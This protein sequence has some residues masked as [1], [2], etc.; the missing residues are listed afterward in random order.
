M[1]LAKNILFCALM[2]MSAPLTSC[3]ESLEERA[4]R[5]AREYTE[6]H[7]PTPP[8]NDVITD[9]IVFDRAG[10][11]SIDEIMKDDAGSLGGVKIK[12]DGVLMDMVVKG[13]FIAIGHNPNTDLFKGQVELKDN[14]Y[15]K[16]EA[17]S[18]V[19][20]SVEGVFAAGDVCDDKYRQAI[21]SAGAGCK[22]ALEAIDYLSTS[23]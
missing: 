18:G 21:T 11:T 3:Q 17:E 5:E 14:G 22:A 8:Q 20:T 19:K 9:S 13:L 6:K 1:R 16:V 10:V 15:I 4:E 7:C 23:K 12:H 2:V